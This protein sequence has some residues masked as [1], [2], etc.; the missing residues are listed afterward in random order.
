MLAQ[1]KKIIKSKGLLAVTNDLGYR[2]L[3]TVQNWI[4]NKRIP[5]TAKNKVE[6]Y[7]QNNQ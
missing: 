3:N 7:L 4:K 1:L 2:S 6:T 5:D